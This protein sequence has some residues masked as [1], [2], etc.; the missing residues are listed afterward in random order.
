MNEGILNGFVLA[1]LFIILYLIVHIVCQ[2]WNQVNQNVD[3]FLD[4]EEKAHRREKES[5][6]DIEKIL[7]SIERVK[8]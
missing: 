7:Q 3:D 6:A 1:A 5:L 8:K 4:K 2:Q